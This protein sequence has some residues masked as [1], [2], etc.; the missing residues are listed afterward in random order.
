MKYNLSKIMKRAW[1]LK[2]VT[3]DIFS[4]CLKKSWAEAKR[5]VYLTGEALYERLVEMGASRWQKGGRDR[6]YLNG[7]GYKLLGLHIERYNTGNIRYAE[8]N[9]ES[10][11]N[12]RARALCDWMSSLYLN[13]ATE[14][15]TW[16]GNCPNS[17]YIETIQHAIHTIT[18]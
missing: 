15:W 9:G 5:P 17:E 1:E 2:K 8:L 11:S 3:D 18:V 7:L 12:S 4:V 10:I 13:V 16:Y 6:I 14:T